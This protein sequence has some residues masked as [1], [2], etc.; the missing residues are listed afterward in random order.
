M[1]S[2]S[3][4]FFR[5]NHLS[6]NIKDDLMLSFGFCGAKWEKVVVNVRFFHIFAT[7]V[8]IF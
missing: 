7:V 5:K 3:V 6:I 8:Y 1:I 4:K 2:L